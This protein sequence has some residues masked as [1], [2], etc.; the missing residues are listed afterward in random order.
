MKWAWINTCLLESG[1][2]DRVRNDAS[3]A[4]EAA[5]VAR[6]FAHL[7]LLRAAAADNSDE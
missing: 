5:Q 4:D 1:T 2:I 7:P 3:T 6:R